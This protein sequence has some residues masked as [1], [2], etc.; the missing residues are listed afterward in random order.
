MK[1]RLADLASGVFAFDI[2]TFS[3]P[4]WFS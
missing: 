4:A 1:S 2:S 3:P